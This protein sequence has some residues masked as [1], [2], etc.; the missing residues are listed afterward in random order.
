MSR[1]SDMYGCYVVTH[2]PSF[3]RNRCKSC[4]CVFGVVVSSEKEKADKLVH[5]IAPVLSS[6][7]LLAYNGFKIQEHCPRATAALSKTA[8]TVIDQFGIVQ[9][10]VRVT[11]YF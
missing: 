5:Y 3:T 9:T 10:A 1:S 7:S 6:F 8:R 11:P 2:E 4:K